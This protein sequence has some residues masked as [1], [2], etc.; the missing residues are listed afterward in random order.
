MEKF[1][2]KGGVPLAGTI[3]PAGNKNGALPILAACLLTEEEVLLRNVPRISDVETMVELIETLGARVEWRGPNTVAIEASGVLH[4]EVD[5]GLSERIRAS[6]LLAGPLLARFGRASM[7]PPGGDVIG[8]RR[9]DPHL[10]AFKEFGATVEH[11]RD[12]VIEAPF[13]LRPCDFLMDEPSVMATENALMTAALTPGSTVIRNAASEPHVQ[14]L[15]RML[16]RMGAR[17]DGIGSNVMTVHGMKSLG[18]CEH[19]IAPDHIEIGSF[20]ALAGVTGGELVV[21]DTL[22]QDLRMIRIVFERLGLHS[23]LQGND[24][25]VPGAQKLVIRDDAGGIQPKV[26]SGPWPAFPADLTSVA[27]ALA[28][29][30]EGSVLIHEKMF[31]NRLFFADKLQVMGAAITICDP[32]RAIVLGPRRLRGE[33]VPA[34]D[35]RAGMAM[36]IAALCADGE[37][38]IGNIGQIDRGYE[39]IDERLRELGARIKRVDDV[40]VP[41]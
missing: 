19:T 39:R 25:I 6:F 37:T 17:I 15:A 32:H 38:E 9:L 21:K 18:G 26:D 16:E 1:I 30:S 8:R 3:V 14:D 24:V 27:L 40:P 11:T 29:Q 31:E 10:D 36:L 13:G 5:R 35:I 33:R 4:C 34:P 28:T 20:M 12:I 23:E 22:P 7:P 2:I 41:A